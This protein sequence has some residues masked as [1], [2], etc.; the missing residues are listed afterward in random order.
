MYCGGKVSVKQDQK[1]IKREL[2]KIGKDTVRGGVHENR[3]S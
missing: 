3:V 1:I 2:D